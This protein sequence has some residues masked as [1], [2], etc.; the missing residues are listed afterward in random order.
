LETS[1]YDRRDGTLRIRTGKAGRIRLIPVA[2]PLARLLDK[3]I[4][5]QRRNSGQHAKT[6][7][8]GRAP[9]R[10]L[11]ARQVQSRFERW[12]TSAGLKSQL[13]IHSFRAGFATTL[14]ER[15]S[16]LLMVSRALGHRDVRPTLRYIQLS[17]Q[18]V[19]KAVEALAEAI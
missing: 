1:D 5:E 14:H 8:P 9:G 2:P 10:A 13:T 4:D 7:F 3:F 15:T 18:K 17:A 12:K 16:D 6:I 19:R 11:T